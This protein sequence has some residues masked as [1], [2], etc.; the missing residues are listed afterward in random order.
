MNGTADLVIRGATVIGPELAMNGSA[1]GVTGG[2]I[3]FVGSQ[4]EAPQAATQVDAEGCFLLPG[5]V[6]LHC[7]GAGGY[8]ATSGKYDRHARDFVSDEATLRQG[9]PV[10]ARTHLLHGTTT[11]ALATSAAEESLL[12]RALGAI[13]ELAAD[14]SAPSRVL[15]VNLEGSYLKDPDYAGAQNPEFFRRPEAA[16]FDRLNAAAGGKIRIVNVAA[17]WGYLATDLITHLIANDVVAACG[18]SGG[19]S[20]D[21]KTCIDA[22]TTLAVH[23]SNGPCST[24]YKPPGKVHEA[25]LADPRVTLELIA[26]GYHVNPRY[27]LSFLK[28]KGFRAALVTDGMLPIDA[29]DISR[30]TDCGMT[31]EKSPDGGVLRLQGSADT[32][33]G[34]LLTMERAVANLTGWLCE[35][36]HGMYQN[37]PV[38]DPPPGREE[39]LVIAS[40]LASGYPAEVMNLRKELGA[41]E[42]G[43]AADLVL[44]DEN[45]SVRNV[46]FGGRE[47]KSD[48]VVPEEAPEPQG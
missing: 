5:F 14:G 25:L 31:G 3:S 35:G 7:H 24:S 12:L 28:A 2:K 43:L 46:W 10:I 32:L 29:E 48:G 17:D 38:I 21:M 40:R 22:G 45:L 19:S 36:L 4:V 37:A 42:T 18:H 8:D 9:M 23:F 13:G 39:A 16:D 47:A 34:S 20:S 6:D 15:G 33:F 27:L 26:D 11:V 41:I 1:V 44:L 30:F